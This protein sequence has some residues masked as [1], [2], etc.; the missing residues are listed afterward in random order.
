MEKLTFGKKYS[1]TI[2]DVKFYFIKINNLWA[3]FL[4]VNDICVTSHW[5]TKKDAIN[6][7]T[8]NIKKY[9]KYSNTTK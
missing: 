3:S 8:A 9:K 5:K 2:N 7:V 4:E 6:R 1:K